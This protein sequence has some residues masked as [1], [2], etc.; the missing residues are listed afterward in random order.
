MNL[1]WTLTA[2]SYFDQLSPAEQS[3]VLHTVKDLATGW[4][5]FEGNQLQKLAGDPDG[6]FSLRVG[7]DL[8]V[9]VQRNGEVVTVVDV[10]RRGQ[11]DGLRR[12]MKLHQPAVG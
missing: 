9:I 5:R 12:V 3:R 2:S 1:E 10:I 7:F 6:L 11:I 4:D 8:R